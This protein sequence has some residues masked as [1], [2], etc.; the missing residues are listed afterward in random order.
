[1]VTGIGRAG[2]PVAD[3]LLGLSGVGSRGRSLS[4][5]FQLR[6]QF[7]DTCSDLIG[8]KAWPRNIFQKVYT[9][10]LP[11]IFGMAISRYLQKRRVSHKR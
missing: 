7:P 6:W 11:V 8:S 5:I 4:A 2:R 10:N 1:M 9:R 3:G